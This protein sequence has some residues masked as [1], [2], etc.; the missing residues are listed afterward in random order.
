MDPFV[1]FLALILLSI[2]LS[3]GDDG[4]TRQPMKARTQ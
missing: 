3:D 1:L 2:F 4:G